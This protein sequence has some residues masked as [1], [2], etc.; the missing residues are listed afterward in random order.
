M[1]GRDLE[2]LVVAE[3]VERLLEA[4]PA[5]RG[6]A[7][8]NVGRRGA[9]VGL[10]LLPA[11]VDPNVSRA[12]LDADDHAF[13]HLLPRLDEGRAALLCGGQPEGKRRAGRRRGERAVALLPEV[14]R[15]APV[16]DADRAHQAGAGGEREEAVPKTDQATGGNHVFQ[17]YAALR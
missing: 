14:A 16:P 10:L 8:G 11:D 13:V 4:L 1:L 9:D 6:E 3:E 17:A 7:D 12:L 5:R 2:Q 15:P